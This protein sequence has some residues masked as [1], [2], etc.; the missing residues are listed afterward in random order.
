VVLQVKQI[1]YNCDAI[2]LLNVDIYLLILSEGWLELVP[3]HLPHLR[4][5][6]L[7]ESRNVCHEY[8]T[9]LMAALPELRVMN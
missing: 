9:N 6:D 5:L 4:L 8:L 2:E 3:S 1:V 7:W